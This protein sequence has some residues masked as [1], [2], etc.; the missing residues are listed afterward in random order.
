MDIRSN[1]LT[2]CFNTNSDPYSS[3]SYRSAAGYGALAGGGITGAIAYRRAYKKALA[4]GMDKTEARKI[5]R[6]QALK[7]GAIGALGGAALNTAGAFKDKAVKIAAK[8]ND[9]LVADELMNKFI[10][11]PTDA[12]VRNARNIIKLS[13]QG[14]TTR[15]GMKMERDR[16]LNKLKFR[17]N[18]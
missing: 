14:M 5:A 13:G 6:K 11:D 18:K 15:N 17:R 9:Q 1:N 16:I 4:Q 12:D 2:R 10:F 7:L 8:H 3:I